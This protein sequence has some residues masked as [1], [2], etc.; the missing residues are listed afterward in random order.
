M[1]TPVLP[2]GQSSDNPAFY[3][4]Y[5]RRQCALPAPVPAQVHANA[6]AIPM[7]YRAP[8]LTARAAPP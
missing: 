5:R 7:I 3:Q 8:W 2:A 4:L 1:G 6:A